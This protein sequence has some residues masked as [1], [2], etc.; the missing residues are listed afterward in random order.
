ML[1]ANPALTP[2]E[3]KAVLQFTAETHAGVDGLVQGAG[4]LNARGAVELAHRLAAGG[5]LDP[6][7]PH[8]DPTPW[9]G[10]VIWGNTRMSGDA[11]EAAAFRTDVAWG[12]AGVVSMSDTAENDNIVWGTACG[13][14]DCHDVVWSTA[15]EG[16]SVVW[17]TS[18]DDERDTIVWG[19]ADPVEDV[20]WAPAIRRPRRIIAVADAGDGL[21]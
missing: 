7:A 20:L 19:T 21:T 5:T 13:G 10:R 8:A 3:V 14:V 1:Q 9:S 2:N 15:D 17:A 6:A 4:F 12:A 11:L 18:S 16:S